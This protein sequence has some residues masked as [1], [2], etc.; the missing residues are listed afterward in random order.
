[1]SGLLALHFTLTS[2]YHLPD[3]QHSASRVGHDALRF[4]VHP[5]HQRPR[6]AQI[7]LWHLHRRHVLVLLV[8]RAFRLDLVYSI[9]YWSLQ[10]GT[11]FQQMHK[12]R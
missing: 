3:N 1:M 10:E 4:Q 5:R 9:R 11:R 6:G 2:P 8:A 12:C 7:Q